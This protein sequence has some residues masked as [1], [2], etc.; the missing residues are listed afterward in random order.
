MLADNYGI[1]LDASEV[2]SPD[3][4]YSV[5]GRG[6]DVTSKAFI[7]RLYADSVVVDSAPNRASCQVTGYTGTR[8]KK[9]ISVGTTYCVKTDQDRYAR[10]TI[11]AVDPD[12]DKVT[13][14]ITVWNK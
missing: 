6:K 1:D 2:E 12:A 9:D 8:Y 4:R 3:W 14:D 10:V 11:T 5:G 7:G 13:L